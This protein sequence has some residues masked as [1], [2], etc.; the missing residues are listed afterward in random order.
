MEGKIVMYAR[1]I[2]NTNNFICKNKINGKPQLSKGYIASY[3]V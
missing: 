3:K 2:V 1:H